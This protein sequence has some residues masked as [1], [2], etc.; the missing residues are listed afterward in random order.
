M[1]NQ[2]LM[3]TM[4]SIIIS[5]FYTPIYENSYFWKTEKRLGF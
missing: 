4:A 5:N 3:E 1:T 2:A